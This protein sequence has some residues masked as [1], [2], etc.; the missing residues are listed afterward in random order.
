MAI[1]PLLLA[2]VLAAQRCGDVA[3]AARR[4][5]GAAAR[6]AAQS[7]AANARG[8]W[9]MAAAQQPPFATAS[10]IRSRF[11][12]TRSIAGVQPAAAAAR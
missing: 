2:Q 10:C 7:S 12:L 4:G 6:G 1:C 11:E 3:F 8:A 5:A 9:C